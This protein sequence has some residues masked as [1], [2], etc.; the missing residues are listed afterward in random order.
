MKDIIKMY[1]VITGACEAGTRYFVENNNLP[2][3]LTV[4]QTIDL[5]QGQY[6]NQQFKKFFEKE[7]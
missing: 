5:T 3:R 2:N 4:K 1:R 7:V 6:G